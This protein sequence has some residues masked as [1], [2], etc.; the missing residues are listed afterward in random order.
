[1]TDAWDLARQSIGRAQ[2]RQKDMYDKNARIPTFR[3]GERV[4]LFKPAEK[5]L[6]NSP[7]PSMALIGWWRWDPTQ[8]RSEELVD[9]KKNLFS[10]HLIDYVDVA[11][12][13]VTPN[14]SEKRKSSV[15]PAIATDTV[16]DTRRVKLSFHLNRAREQPALMLCR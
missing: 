15:R 12:K 3:E 7:D 1:M 11:R 6:V 8:Q 4:F 2:R 14:R 16:P 10:C 5:R 9:P 13:S